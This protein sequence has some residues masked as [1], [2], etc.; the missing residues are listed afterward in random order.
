VLF[1]YAVIV[2]RTPYTRWFIAILPMV[3]LVVYMGASA[4]A[5]PALAAFFSVRLVG[6]VYDAEITVFFAA[7]TI[8]LTRAARTLRS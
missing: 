8:W 2:F 1:V 4:A 3:V 7:S 5:P 6:N